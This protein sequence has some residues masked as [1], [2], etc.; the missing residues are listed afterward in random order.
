MKSTDLLPRT[1]IGACHVPASYVTACEPLAINARKLRRSG[2]PELGNTFF[3][4]VGRFPD[5][6]RSGK[7]GGRAIA[8][9]LRIG[10]FRRGSGDGNG[11]GRGVVS[12]AGGR[13][14][15][16]MTKYRAPFSSELDRPSGMNV[17]DVNRCLSSILTGKIPSI[18]SEESVE[19][20][21]RSS[22]G[23]Q[24]NIFITSF[25]GF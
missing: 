21:G 1:T 11:R 18:R 7:G 15:A 13:V 17:W 6:S 20:G 8:I 14:G 19:V 9:I 25:A 24:T 10:R 3:F 16:T 22:L 12:S 5:F 2:K 23:E 4:L